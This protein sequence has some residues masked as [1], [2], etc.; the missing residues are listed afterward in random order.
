MNCL[1]YDC[2]Y[3]DNGYCS[4]SNYI[5]IDENGECD[6]KVCVISCTENEIE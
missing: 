3:N 2:I 5:T 4:R 6:S 1:C